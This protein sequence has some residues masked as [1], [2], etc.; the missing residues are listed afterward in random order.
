MFC[1]R[2]LAC[3]LIKCVSH[4]VKTTF[5]KPIEKFIQNL[6]IKYYKCCNIEATVGLY[7]FHLFKVMHVTTQKH[8][9]CK[10]NYVLRVITLQHIYAL[11]EN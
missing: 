8:L 3:S 5:S 7:A 10:H 4:H 6:L 11:Q 9:Q 1:L 2:Y